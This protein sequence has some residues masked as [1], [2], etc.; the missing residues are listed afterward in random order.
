MFSFMRVEDAHPH[1]I[2]HERNASCLALGGG[3]TSEL[4]RLA[5]HD[6]VAEFEAGWF[7]VFKRRTAREARERFDELA[8]TDKQLAL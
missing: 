3:P 1:L 8:T 4:E 7:G 2:C 5:R 6:V